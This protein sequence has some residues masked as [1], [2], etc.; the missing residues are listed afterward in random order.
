VCLDDFNRGDL[1]AAH[2]R[3]KRGGGLS[4]EAHTV[5]DSLTLLEGPFLLRLLML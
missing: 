4:C 1:T 2:E 5:A 3:G